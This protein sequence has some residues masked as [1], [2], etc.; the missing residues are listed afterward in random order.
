[1]SFLLGLLE[2]SRAR[3]EG[4]RKQSLDS[5]PPAPA[6][7]S[8]SKIDFLS[9]LSDFQMVSSL[10]AAEGE[11]ERKRAAEE[12]A[13]LP[14]DGSE[15]ERSPGPG[16]RQPHRPRAEICLSVTERFSGPVGVKMALVLGEPV[17]WGGTGRRPGGLAD[18]RCV[19]ES[20]G[21]GFK[22]RLRDAN[23]SELFSFPDP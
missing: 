5:L 2:C 8:C 12:A 13:G 19:W 15:E 18:G 22:S 23:S 21:T 10:Q 11:R 9:E 16:R 1:M 20:D 7:S 6:H 3:L 14:G 4:E 17:L